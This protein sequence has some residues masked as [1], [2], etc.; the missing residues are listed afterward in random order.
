MEK[1]LTD[2]KVKEE[3]DLYKGFIDLKE[4]T[5]TNGEDEFTR[6]ILTVPS[7]VAAIVYDTKKDKYLF[8]EQYRAGVGGIMVEIVG[9][10]MD[11]G[12]KAEQAIKREIMEEIGYR[13]DFISHIKDFY[14]T[15]GRATEVTSLFYCEVSEKVNDGGGVDYDEIINTVE[16][17]KLGLGGKIF[18]Q[19]PSKPSK[20]HEETDIPY[21]LIDAKSLVAVMWLENSNVLKDMAEVITQ[22]KLRSF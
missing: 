22:A 5:I 14:L 9:G 19:D 3:K 17:S 16:V 20:E 1:V 12:E 10:A 2:Y 6:E 8:V 13:V 7:S 11:E 18:F 21:Q 4:L 15:P